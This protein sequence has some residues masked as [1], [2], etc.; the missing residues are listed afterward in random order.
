MEIA[1]YNDNG[2]FPTALQQPTIEIISP[3]S[4][5]VFECTTFSPFVTMTFPGGLF[6]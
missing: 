2:K 3:Y 6:N 1:L 4:P 5:D